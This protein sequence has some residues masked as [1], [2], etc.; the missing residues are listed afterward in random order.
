[1]VDKSQPGQGHGRHPLEEAHQACEALWQEL[2]WGRRWRRG[3]RCGRPWPA[4][5][6]CS[7]CRSPPPVIV[8][9]IA[10]T[11]WLERKSLYYCHCHCHC[12]GNYQCSLFWL[13][14]T[15]STISSSLRMGNLWGVMIDNYEV[16]SMQ[17]WKVCRMGKYVGLKSMQD[18]KV[19][20][21][22]TSDPRTVCR[23][24]IV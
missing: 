6:P 23:H 8:I 1:M 22:S 5:S 15:C 7:S 19:A 14:S 18:S 16:T 13:S 11:E 9:V 21:L 12:Q 24:C 4:G 3:R 2:R 10:I 20:E 17:D